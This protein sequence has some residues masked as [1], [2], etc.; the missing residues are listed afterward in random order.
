VNI[1]LE[2]FMEHDEQLPPDISDLEEEFEEDGSVHRAEIVFEVSTPFDELGVRNVEFVALLSRLRIAS[3]KSPIG[4]SRIHQ[5]SARSL[6]L[7]PRCP[8]DAVSN[9]HSALVRSNGLISNSFSK[10]WLQGQLK[11]C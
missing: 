5:S 6:N 3:S 2:N 1:V 7:T 9:D 8:M 4:G 11:S 10:S